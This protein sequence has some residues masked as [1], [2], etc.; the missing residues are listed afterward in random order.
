MIIFIILTWRFDKLNSVNSYLKKFLNKKKAF[1]IKLSN[2]L[3]HFYSLDFSIYISYD[4]ICY[5]KL[6]L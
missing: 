3:N 6:V 1:Q 2:K 4:F 5:S